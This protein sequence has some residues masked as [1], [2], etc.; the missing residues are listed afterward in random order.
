[1]YAL[2]SASTITIY[3]LVYSDN[4]LHFHCY[5]HNISADA[6]FG[7]STFLRWSMSNSGTSSLTLNLIHGYRLF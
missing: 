2:T 6:S 7:F 4:C 5:I 1:M 3:Y